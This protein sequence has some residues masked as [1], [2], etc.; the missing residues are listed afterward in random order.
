MTETMVALQVP[1][2]PGPAI[3]R[4]QSWKLS[5][6]YKLLRLRECPVSDL[7]DTPEKAV[8]FWRTHVT[9]APWYNPDVEVLCVLL[10]NTRRRIQGFTL[11]AT[12]TLDSLHFHARE[13]FKVAVVQAAA[14]VI[15]AHNHPS[16][17]PTPSEQDIRMTRDIIRAGQLLRIEVLDHVVVGRPT[18]E[19]PGGYCSLRELGY[20]QS[21]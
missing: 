4:P 9:V 6:E 14:G 20:C 12:G 10:L 5:A 2:I 18:P 17:D 1:P 7:C 8:A 19:R 11:V 15:L 3:R 16:G 13:I 21:P